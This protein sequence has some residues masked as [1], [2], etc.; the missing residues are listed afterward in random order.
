MSCHTAPKQPLDCRSDGSWV[1]KHAAGQ[2]KE[3]VCIRCPLGC[4]LQGWLAEGE[5]HVEGN[6][7][8]RGEAYFIKEAANPS[9]TVTGLVRVTGGQLPVVSVK[10]V[11]EVPKAR[12]MD[13][14][15]GL[16]RLEV[17]APVSI[18][19]VVEED[20]LGTGAS[21]IATKSVGKKA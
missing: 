21:L 11:P 14:A 20:F 12:V 16:A 3:L 15:R 6:G 9:R 10:T 17:R 1:E 2:P 13:V 4:A 7:C 8:P 5:W 19:Q 18:G